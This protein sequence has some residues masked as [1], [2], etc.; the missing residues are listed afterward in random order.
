ME[1]DLSPKEVSNL[2]N[3]VKKSHKALT[4]ILKES[5]EII[6][7]GICDT[8]KIA[9]INKTAYEALHKLELYCNRDGRLK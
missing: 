3:G 8:A 5:A 6:D 7:S 1:T 9:W 2:H 4:C